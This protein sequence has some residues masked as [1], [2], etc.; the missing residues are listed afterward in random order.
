MYHRKTATDNFLVL[1]PTSQWQVIQKKT[2]ELARKMKKPELN[3]VLNAGAMSIS[4]EESGNG[5]ILIPPKYTD[6][7]K[8]HSELVFVGNTV[9]IEL[10]NIDIYEEN[11]V[12]AEATTAIVH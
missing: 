2:E 12:E 11:K 8:P 6:Y 3:R 4:F 5:R 9:Q 1:Y 10:W 7:F